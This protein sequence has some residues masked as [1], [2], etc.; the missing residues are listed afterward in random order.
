MKRAKTLTTWSVN[1]L[2][3]TQVLSEISLAL[4]LQIMDR[5]RINECLRLQR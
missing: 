1:C 3:L 5:Q 4:R 2:W